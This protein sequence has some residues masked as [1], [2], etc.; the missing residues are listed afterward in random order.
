MVPPSRK[1]TVPVAA[2]GDVVAVK[3]TLAPVAGDVF[4]AVSDVVVAVP[5]WVAV[6]VT[7]EDALAA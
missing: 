7:A 2:E 4:E 6:T 5:P 3:V 1:V